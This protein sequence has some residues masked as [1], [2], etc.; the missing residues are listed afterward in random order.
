LVSK[1]V[2]TGENC[3]VGFREKSVRVK[4]TLKRLGFRERG[5]GRER[6]GEM[7]RERKRE[8]ERERESSRLR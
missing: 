1:T 6:E 7:E 4:E 3:G 8:R 2:S 5:G